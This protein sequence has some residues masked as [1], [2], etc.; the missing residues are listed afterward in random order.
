M[1]MLKMEFPVISQPFATK[2][3]AMA[4]MNT[5]GRSLARNQKLQ[6]KIAT[7]K[8]TIKVI[9]LATVVFR[10]LGT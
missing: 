8:Y 2:S 3:D 1:Y 6:I 10:D 5:V 7:K 4:V 9:V